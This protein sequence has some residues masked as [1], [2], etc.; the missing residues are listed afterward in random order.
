MAE[1]DAAV[2]GD[3]GFDVVG[4]GRG[5]ECAVLTRGRRALRRARGPEVLDRRTSCG[6]VCSRTGR[7]AAC[8]D[9]PLR[10][11]APGCLLYVARRRRGTYLRTTEFSFDRRAGGGSAAT[12]PG[13]QR[14][15]CRQAIWA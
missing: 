9:R 14:L 7:D 5:V 10:A 13:T 8:C 3:S 2:P 1:T 4:T 11:V 15:I 12:Y 6:L